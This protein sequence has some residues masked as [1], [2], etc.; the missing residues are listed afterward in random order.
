MRTGDFTGGRRDAA[1]ATSGER[2]RNARREFQNIGR[3]RRGGGREGGRRRANST[4]A[5]HPVINDAM[6]SAWHRLTDESARGSHRALQ[7]GRNE[8]RE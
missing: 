3:G 4:N 7:N 1:V 8:T 2:I 6:R 5:Y